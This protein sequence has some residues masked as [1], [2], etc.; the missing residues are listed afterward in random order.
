MPKTF[1]K[2]R[3]R[4]VNFRLT[5]QEFESILAACQRHGHNLSD[6]ARNAVL[7]FAARSSAGGPVAVHMT[8]LDLKLAQLDDT[9]SHLVE[10]IEHLNNRIAEA[11]LPRRSG[12]S[13]ES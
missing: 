3:S 1:S 12:N 5:E 9:F 7:D 2:P 13:D 4:V 6:F 10:N 11:S 8:S